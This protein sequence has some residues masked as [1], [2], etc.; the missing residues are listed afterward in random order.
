MAETEKKPLPD[1]E[2]QELKEAWEMRHK[3][4][5]QYRAKYEQALKDIHAAY[6][7]QYDAPAEKSIKGLD[8]IVDTALEVIDYGAGIVRTGA[9][10]AGQRLAGRSDVVNSQ[11]WKDAFNPADEKPAP[12]MNEFF[13]RGGVPEGPS[14]SQGPLAPFFAEPGKEDTPWYR[15]VKGG[16]LDWT[17]RGTAAGLLDMAASPSGIRKALRGEAR[18]EAAL[19]GMKSHE[20]AAFLKAEADRQ[21]AKGSLR[22]IM[23]GVV[24]GVLDPAGELAEHL[25]K[26]YYRSAFREADQ[27]AAIHGGKYAERPSDVLMRHGVAGTAD[28]VAKQA[29]ELRA[30]LARQNAKIVEHADQKMPIVR[31]DTQELLDPA[32]KHLVKEADQMGRTAGAQG[33]AVQLYDE[34]APHM[35]KST[36]GL[37]EVDRLVN[38]YQT[39]ARSQ[40]AYDKSP[41]KMSRAQ[42][43]GENT[44]KSEVLGSTYQ[45][46][47]ESGRKQ[48]EGALDDIERGAGGELYRNNREIGALIGAEPFLDD[49]ARFNAWRM[50]REMGIPG[51]VGAMIAG[52]PAYVLE[53]PK[54]LAGAAAV[55]GLGNLTAAKTGLGLL[56]AKHGRKLTNVPRALLIEDRGEEMRYTPWQLMGNEMNLWK[57]D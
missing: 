5:E 29:R 49:A 1:A 30:L 21:A 54:L 12:T 22:K 53:S 15:P 6:V 52:L 43:A 9:A 42:K 4:P 44:V 50:G 56:G 26:G 7:E 36:L 32:V 34:L 48:L 33:A 8:E 13:K 17:A 14:L 16:K 55:G 19:K 39:K 18:R 45:K 24:P 35:D 25:G 46:I 40:G 27:N 31:V 10:E 38:T 41:L 2:Y 57:R 23:E 37:P 11:D 28:S 51:M 47:A 20:V 3:V